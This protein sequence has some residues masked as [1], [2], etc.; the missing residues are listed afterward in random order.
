LEQKKSD[1]EIS[2]AKEQIEKPPLEKE[3][4]VFWISRFKSGDVNDPIYRASIV[5]IFVNSVFLYDVELVVGFN[6][7]DGTKTLSL[8]Q[9]EK[10]VRGRNGVGSYLVQCGQ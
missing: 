8:K 9:W 1:I 4:I 6:W 10:A 7:K 3:H 5:D 2:I